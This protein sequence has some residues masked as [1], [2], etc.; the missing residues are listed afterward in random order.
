MQ[1]KPVFFKGSTYY[2]TSY[3]LRYIYLLSISSF[4]YASHE[5]D[6]QRPSVSYS[7]YL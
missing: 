6:G 1:F 3:Y 7:A 5:S 4:P 2:S